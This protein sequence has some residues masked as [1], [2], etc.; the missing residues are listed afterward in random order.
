[1]IALFQHTQG[2]VITVEKF[3]MLVSLSDHIRGLCTQLHLADVHLKNPEKK[4]KEGK[5]IRCRVSELRFM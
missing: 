3:G 1:M 4:L 5:V 2:K